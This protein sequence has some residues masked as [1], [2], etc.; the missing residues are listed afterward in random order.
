M[1]RFVIQVGILPAPLFIL[2]T[3]IVLIKWLINPDEQLFLVFYDLFNI[4]LSIHLSVRISVCAPVCWTV[5]L[6][7][8][9]SR[10]NFTNTMIAVI[11]VF[12]FILLLL[13]FREERSNYK[14]T[15]FYIF[16]SLL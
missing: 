6:P 3:K 7:V 8:Y 12:C 9:L 1:T 11:F 13:P 2:G 5:F 15:L 14:N 10:G 4:F 16:S